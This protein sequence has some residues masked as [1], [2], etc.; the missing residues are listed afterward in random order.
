VAALYR[1]HRKLITTLTL[2]FLA[3]I[4]LFTV[5]W[6]LI[7]PQSA[8]FDLACDIV[9]LS[10]V[11]WCFLAITTAPFAL[12]FVLLI[13]TVRKVTQLARDP[14]ELPLLRLVLRDGVWA[15]FL[16]WGEWLVVLPSSCAN[17]WTS[18][19]AAGRGFCTC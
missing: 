4:V 18:N 5:V 6:A 11:R 10:D 16:I 8:T 7:F 15:F 1:G 2:F 19:G 12:D 14:H 9:R 13:L 3:E 17:L